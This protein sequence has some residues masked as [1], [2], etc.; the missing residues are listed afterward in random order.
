MYVET[1]AIE[2]SLTQCTEGDEVC[3][4]AL[5]SDSPLSARL[6]VLGVLAGV[7]IR[8]ARSGSPLIIEVGETRLC[9]RANEADQV[10]VRPLDAPWLTDLLS[11]LEDASPA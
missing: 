9:L 8:V 6:R 2:M 1:D 11:G 4:V 10:R 7:P 5:G 3:V